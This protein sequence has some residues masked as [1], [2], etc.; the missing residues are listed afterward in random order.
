VAPS[1]N[2]AANGENKPQPAGSEETGLLDSFS[3]GGLG[4]C[5]Y[6]AAKAGKKGS[7]KK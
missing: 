6:R 2:Q 4:Y 1:G 7:D 5:L 3:Y